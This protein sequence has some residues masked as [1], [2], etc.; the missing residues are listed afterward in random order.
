[1]RKWWGSIGITVACIL[2]ALTGAVAEDKD[3]VKMDAVVVTATGTE[4]PVKD[5][6]QSVTVITEK[7]I[8]ERQA[9]RVEEMLRYVPGVTINQSGSRGG[10]TSLYLRGGERDQTQVLF[11]G[12]RL[13][14]AGG[15]FDFSGLTTDNLNRIEVV[16]GPMS[17]L[18]GADAM[19]GVVNLITKKGVGPPTLTLSSGWGPHAENAKFIGEQRASFIGSYKNFGFSVGYSRIDDPGI[20]PIN[21]LFYSNNLIGRLDLDLRDNLSITHHTY[22]LD[23]RFGISSENAGDIYDPKGRGGPGL[24]PTQNQHRRM[25]L[26]GLTVNYW[27]F[28]W[29]ENE[30]TMAYTQREQ[31]FNDPQNPFESDF[32]QLFGAYWSRDFERRLSLDYHSNLRFGSRDKVESISTLGFHYR[33]EQLKQWLWYGQSLLGGP[34]AFFIKTARH[35]TA[36]Y[37]QEQLNLWNRVFL[38]GGFRVENNSVFSKTQFLP[39]ASAAI[40]FPETDTTIRAAGGRA[41]KEP[42]FLE[43]FS[44]SQL[45]VANPDLKPEVNVS[46]EVGID[47]FLWDNRVKLTATYFENNFKDFITFV[48]RPWPTP[49]S[50]ENIG[51]VRVNGLEF[52]ARVQPVKGLTLGLVYTNLLYFKVTNDEGINSLY[53]RTGLPLLR[54]PRHTFSFVVDYVWDRLNLNLSG[55]YIGSRDD[56]WFTFAFPFTFNSFRVNNTD[57]FILNLAGSYDLV[58]DWGYINKVQLWAR[59]NNLLDRDYEE[60]FG[61]SS[62]RFF[63]VGGLRVV[64]G[65]KPQADQKKRVSQAHPGLQGRFSPGFSTNFQE[66]NRI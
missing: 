17:A 50:F 55:L 16:R 40:R 33:D 12:I 48:S 30:F 9:I 37:A 63:M 1:M 39:R 2:T 53:F 10:L 26:Q 46:W 54:R 20:L 35:A 11:N 58:R 14:N 19:V 22:L 43:S 59:L 65:L 57:A 6:T 23:N 42:T 64:F 31:D 49:S 60:T 4:V 27:P 38:V 25:L 51:G 15:D 7:E 24:D 66:D 61:Y 34:S 29:W 5:S 41:I 56:S 52:S 62:P 13:N 32:D 8:Q 36:Y 44:Q 21:N 28:L 3:A 47:Q 18:Y 45:S